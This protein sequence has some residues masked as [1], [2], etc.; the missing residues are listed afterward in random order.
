MPT[1]TL[2]HRDV[3][4]WTLE[5]VRQSAWS[6]QNPA[7]TVNRFALVDVDSCFASCERVFHPDLYGRPVVVLSNNDGCVV[8]MSREAKALGIT[9]GTPWFQIRALEQTKGVVARSSNYEL[10]GSISARVMS[11]LRKFSPQVEVYSIDEAFVGLHG[12]PAQMAQTAAQMRSTIWRNLG[13]PVSVGVA[14]SRTLAKLASHG[15][16]HTPRL[17]GVASWDFYTPT[18]QET[19]LRSTP[20]SELWGVGRRLNQRLE[21]LGITDAWQLRNSDPIFIRKKFGVTLQRTVFELRGIPCIDIGLRDAERKYQVRYSRSFSTPIHSLTELHQVLSIYAQNV[22]RRLRRQG[23]LAG[24]AWAF[25]ATAWYK[26]PYSAISGALPLSPRT[27]D[28]VQV[29]DAVRSVLEPQ[30]NPDA[31]YVRAGISLQDLAPGDQ[32]NLLP[33]FAPDPRRYQVGQTIDRVN[34]TLGEGS[35]GLGLAGFQSP[36]DWQMKREMLS[37]RGTTHWSEL[38]VVR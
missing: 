12:A 36:P 23:S 1:P 19:I 9:M 10:Y 38:T 20:V 34:A 24:L 32:D 5:S 28:P 6:G 7:Q 14:P 3:P 37:N 11:L 4:D 22:T 2:E 27:D 31:Y 8:A 35:V 26:Q 33:I 15:A 13:I 29:L 30:F 21:A 25:A 17:Q 16:K 18:Q